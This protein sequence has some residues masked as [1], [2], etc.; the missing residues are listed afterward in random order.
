MQTGALTGYFDVAQVALYGFW[1]FFAGL[2]YYLHRED[3]REGYPLLQD[4]PNPRT[5]IEGFPPTP[6]AKRFIL[7]HGGM[8]E[9]RAAERP[10]AALPIGPY[11]GAP[12]EPT[13]N[14]MI[15]AI[16]PASY[17]MRTDRP[18]VGFDDRLP[19]IVPLRVARDF[20]VATED[21]DPRGMPVVGGDNRIAGQVVDVWVDR[22]ETIIRYLEV[23]VPTPAG[24]RR[25]LLPMNLAKV[26]G[27]L[28]PRVRARSITAAQFADVPTLRNPD[29]V[30]LLEEDMI[31]GYYG[32]GTL[33][34]T[35]FRLGPLL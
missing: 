27:G 29:Q 33:Y 31:V 3:K 22:S 24:P 15:D 20:F 1:A 32:G 4:R 10:I 28:R 5:V 23:E 11:P 16:G 19:K 7:G 13:G 30:T 18:D 26:T 25:A 9:T 12:L 35:P 34:A 2:V 21:P 17:A 8:H 6:P 14:P